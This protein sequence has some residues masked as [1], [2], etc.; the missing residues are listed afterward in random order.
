M[1]NRFLLLMFFMGILCFNACTDDEPK[2]PTTSATKPNIL[3]I[4]ADDMGIDATPGYS[5][6]NEKPNMPNLQT[7]MSDGLTFDNMWA[8]PVCSPTRSAI[9][10][11]K[12]GYRTGVLNA[13]TLSSIPTT[14]KTLHA[15][16]D[17]NNLGYNHS[18]I[19][20]WHLSNDGNTATQMGIDYYTGLV[21]GALQDYYQWNIF[22]NG[23]TNQTT[24]YATTKFTDLAIDWIGQQNKPWFCWLAYTTPHTPFHLPPSGTHSQG[25]LPT[26][27]ASIDAD[28]MPYFLAMM[29]N[30]DYEIGRL[31]NSMSTAE[32]EN[33]IIIFIG[34]NG[35]TRTVHQLP[36]RPKS[37]KGSLYQGGVHVPM[38]IAGK[39][40]SRVGEREAALVNVTDLF[41][42]IAN[43]AGTNI[44]TYKDSYAFD[45]F[46]TA[47]GSGK[48]NYNYAEISDNT[49]GYTI[50]NMQYKLI[51]NDDGTEEFYDLSSDAYETNDLLQNTLMTAQQTAKTELENEAVLIRQ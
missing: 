27:Q 11:G 46:L 40:V 49:S 29:E 31:L 22:E 50:R 32:R 5:T 3:L 16:L 24:E 17:D 39:G 36:Y 47:T 28:P 34:D 2:T 51:V 44:E 19:G 6:G 10:T 30:M 15:Y 18:I 33:T 9:L 23:T 37:S 1:S 43:L 7:L 38:V 48:R 4:I 41:I 25:N 13:T 12:Y 42:T 21:T 20:K 35:T 14:E 8:N 45:N 26:D